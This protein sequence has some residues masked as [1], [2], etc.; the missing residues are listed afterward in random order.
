MKKK[1]KLLTVLGA[2]LALSAS[3]A[4]ADMDME[5]SNYAGGA[6]FDARS[7]KTER[8]TIGGFIQTQYQFVDVNDEITGWCNPQE[9]NNFLM[10]HI[11]L[12]VQAELGGGWSAM[13]NVDFA[14]KSSQAYG[15]YYRNGSACQDPVE[16]IAREEGELNESNGGYPLLRSCECKDQCKIF[17]DSAYIQK[18]WCD[19]TFRFGYQKVSWGLENNVPEHHLKTINRS[20]ANN[21]FMNLGRRVNGGN[22]AL[23]TI[24]GTQV[25]TNASPCWTWVGN[26]FG[27]RH[28][29]IYVAGETCN[30]HYSAALVNGYQGLCMNSKSTNNSL[31]F[32]G[33]LAFEFEVCETDFIAGVNAGYQP[34]GSNALASHDHN[35]WGFNPYFLATWNRLTVLGE[36]FYGQVQCG[37]LGQDETAGAAGDTT[38]IKRGNANP[39]GYTIIPSFMLNDHWELVGRFSYVNADCLHMTIHNT[40]GCAPDD[41]YAP[42]AAGADPTIPTLISS[43]TLFEKVYAGYLGINYYMLDGAV[44]VM[45]GLEEAKFK[46]RVFGADSGEAVANPKDDESGIIIGKGAKVKSARAAIQILF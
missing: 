2:G 6:A 12:F 13:M 41:G 16:I 45:F 26:R 31:G 5:K 21:F 29:G 8:I 33:N 15:D 23:P 4:T 19:A 37:T 35:V 9:Y 28:V 17:V 46:N 27:D 36:F 32:Y 30:F 10:S 25:V 20:V 42:T 22:H 1:S 3:W 38:A 18:I 24:D 44:K 11:R 39:W 14:G 34:K 43:N 7:S 40:Y